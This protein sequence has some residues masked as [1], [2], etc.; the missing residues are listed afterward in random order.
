MIDNTS[1]T[2]AA[3][4]VAALLAAV[5]LRYYRRSRQL[6]RQLAD[7][8]GDVYL[9]KAA[10]DVSEQ[11]RLAALRALNEA[12]LANTRMQKPLVI[13]RFNGVDYGE[14]TVTLRQHNLN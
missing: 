8:R 6:E 14:Y 7:L 4:C 10:A 1:T 3:M 12:L 13:M 9:V 2:V 11:R 5:A